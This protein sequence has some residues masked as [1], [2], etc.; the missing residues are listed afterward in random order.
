VILGFDIES[1]FGSK[2]ASASIWGPRVVRPHPNPADIR[3]IRMISTVKKGTIEIA[4]DSKSDC[5][6]V[7]RGS[8][9]L[10][11]GRRNEDVRNRRAA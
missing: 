2:R 7:E 6:S 3:R 9:M 5:E 8:H 1:D 10:K 4:E 11:R